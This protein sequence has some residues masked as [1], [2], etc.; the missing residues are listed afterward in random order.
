MDWQILLTAFTMIFVTMGPIKILIVYAEKTATIAP[1]IRRRVA[2]KAVAIASVIGLLFVLA[3]KIL[4]DLFKFSIGSLQIAGGLILLI[5]AIRMVLSESE[6]HEKEYS[7]REAEGLAVYPFA[8]PLMASPMGIVV[9]TVYSV[10]ADAA[11]EQIIW[12]GVVFLSV[13]L[14]NLIAL[15]AEERVLNYISPELLQVAERVLGI[16]L[17]ALSVQTIFSGLVSLWEQYGQAFN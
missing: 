13:M 12:L 14:I 15:L 8:M 1:A 17:A 7:E 4:M 3:G 10:A 6:T 5:F 16:L 11:G 9:L 2:L